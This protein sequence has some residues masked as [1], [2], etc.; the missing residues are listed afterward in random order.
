MFA[1]DLKKFLIKRN[2]FLIIRHLFP[3]KKRFNVL[4]TKKSSNTNPCVN[5]KRKKT[6]NANNFIK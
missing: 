4:L 1:N 5:I 3:T 2:I 6:Q